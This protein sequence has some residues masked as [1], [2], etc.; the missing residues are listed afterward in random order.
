VFKHQLVFFWSLF[1]LQLATFSSLE[2]SCSTSLL[3]VC[4]RQCVL[5]S[6]CLGVRNFDSF[7]SNLTSCAHALP[8]LCALASSYV[9]TSSVTPAASD[10]TAWRVHQIHCVRK[11]QR[12][13]N[14]CSLFY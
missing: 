3:R 5:V 14:V 11:R 1:S 7:V 2:S 12:W 13:L 10:S 4:E 9:L 8:Y 6:G